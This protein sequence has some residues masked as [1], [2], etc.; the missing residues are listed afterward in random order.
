MPLDYLLGALKKKDR[1]CKTE[2]C[3]SEIEKPQ[4]GCAAHE[5]KEA[6]SDPKRSRGLDEDKTQRALTVAS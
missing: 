4:P 1:G 6:M 2:P 5:A 3:A